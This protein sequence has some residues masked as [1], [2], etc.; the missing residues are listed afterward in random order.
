VSVTA[1][2]TASLRLNIWL[3]CSFS[4]CSGDLALRNS[5]NA[6]AANNTIATKEG[7]S[8]ILSQLHETPPTT[9]KS[10]TSVEIQDMR[11]APALDLASTSPLRTC[12]PKWAIVAVLETK[13][14]AREES[15]RAFLVERSR[16][17][18]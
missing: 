14:E 3:S 7:T 8:R 9:I 10:N 4:G 1:I 5:R 16:L 18:T 6:Q 17:A 15:M 13:P 12:R 2:M 11:A